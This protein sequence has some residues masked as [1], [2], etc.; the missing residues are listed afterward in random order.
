MSN[1]L[2]RIRKTFNDPLFISAPQGMVPTPVAEKFVGRVG[3]ALQLLN[4]S[5]LEGD[6]FHPATADKVFRVR[7]SDMTE[8]LYLPGLGEILQRE[9]AGIHIECYYS[10]RQDM[11]NELATGGLDLAIDIPLTNDLQLRHSPLLKERYVCILR[12]DHPLAR[13]SL[14]LEQYLSLGRI[15]VSSRGKGFGVVDAALN[16]LG[17]HLNIQMR[18]QH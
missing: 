11:P 13:G 3:E 8:A 6:H 9:A 18:V 16:K 7:M 12:K 4:S 2:A 5:V 15:H 10:N 14:T 1:A 17:K